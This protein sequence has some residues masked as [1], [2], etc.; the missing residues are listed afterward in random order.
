[1]TKKTITKAEVKKLA[2][3]NILQ[4]V[5]TKTD[6]EDRTMICT[7]ISDLLPPVLEIDKVVPAI[8]PHPNVLS[9]WDIE[10]NG[11][12]SFRIDSI[13]TIDIIEPEETA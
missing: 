13:K 5:F 2:V 1:M 10:R 11:W 8:E 7:L 6:G 12:R 3:S 4:V 9:V